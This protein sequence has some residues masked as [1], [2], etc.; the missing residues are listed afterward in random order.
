MDRAGADRNTRGE[1]CVYMCASVCASVCARASGNQK[2][3][4]W[5]YLDAHLGSG[6]PGDLRRTQAW[7]QNCSAIFVFVRCGGVRR[8]LERDV[9]GDPPSVCILFLIGFGGGGEQ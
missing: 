4:K 2:R 8:R 1:Q 5:A 6:G 9:C 3:P 7:I